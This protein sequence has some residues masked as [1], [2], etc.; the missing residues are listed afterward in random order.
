ML[1]IVSKNRVKGRIYNQGSSK[2]V[3]SSKT[4]HIVFPYNQKEAWNIFNVSTYH[5]GTYNPGNICLCLNL[6]I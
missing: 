4:L 6:D 1:I 2:K 3:C 5:V